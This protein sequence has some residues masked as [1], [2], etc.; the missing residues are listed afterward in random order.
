MLLIGYWTCSVVLTQSSNVVF[1][2]PTD[3][4]SESIVD[5]E[6]VESFYC[7]VAWYVTV[8]AK[9]CQFFLEIKGL[10][11]P[12]FLK[13]VLQ[14]TLTQLLLNLAP[15]SNGIHINLDNRL[16]KQITLHLHMLTPSLNFSVNFILNTWSLKNMLTFSWLVRVSDIFF[17]TG[18]RICN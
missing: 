13:N 18:N 11:C 5:L 2:A 14:V 12:K 1:V 16:H 17:S 4:Q 9:I 6:F 15:M 3:W 10:C 8:V 7:G